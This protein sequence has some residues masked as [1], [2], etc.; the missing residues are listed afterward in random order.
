MAATILNET[1]FASDWIERQLAPVEENAIRGAYDAAERLLA[2][3]EM[4]QWWADWL[5]RM[6]FD[7]EDL[8]G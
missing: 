2:R 7:V 5:D 6:A 4:M 8:I 1:G 3:T